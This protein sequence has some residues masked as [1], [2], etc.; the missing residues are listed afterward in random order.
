M[1]RCDPPV[2][3]NLKYEHRYREDRRGRCVV[4]VS[5]PTDQRM[6]NYDAAYPA[7]TYLVLPSRIGKLLEE[8][9]E[10]GIAF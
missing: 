3:G 8:M 5:D 2:T 6:A 10:Q 1:A 7:P 4:L 9:R